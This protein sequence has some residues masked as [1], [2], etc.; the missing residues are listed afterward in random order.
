MLGLLE[1]LMKHE[2]VIL[3]FLLQSVADKTDI[4]FTWNKDV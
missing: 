1:L 3:I 2:T 4:L